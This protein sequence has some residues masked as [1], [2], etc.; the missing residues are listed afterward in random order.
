MDTQHPDPVQ[1]ALTRGGERVAQI[2]SL[3]TI[4]AQQLVQR[5]AQREAERAFRDEQVARMVRDQ[6]RAT[7]EADRVGWAPA[8]DPR[9]LAQAD[10]LQ[11]VRAWAA[12]APHAEADPTAESALRKCEDRLR[13]LHPYAIARYD[14]LREDGRSPLEAMSE[15]MPLFARDPDVRTGAPVP[16]R[17]TLEGR[18]RSG[19]N[20]ADRARAANRSAGVATA[21]TADATT[22]PTPAQL[23]AQCFPQSVSEAVRTAAAQPKPTAPTR[24]RGRF[25]EMTSRQRRFTP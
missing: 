2:A 1:D 23:A 19:E 18:A 10:L 17:L 25:T 14:R 7:D 8:H 16:P 11:T 21:A 6:H 22:D 3:V 15:A 12:A 24:T 13:R 9:W 20:R 4:A 5:R